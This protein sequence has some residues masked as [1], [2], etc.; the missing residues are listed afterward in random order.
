MLEPTTRVMVRDVNGNTLGDFEVDGD[1]VG[2]NLRE[3]DTG[4]VLVTVELRE[5]EDPD[6]DDED[7]AEA[8]FREH[9]QVI[10]VRMP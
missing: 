2:V 7:E 4:T 8:F 10:P 1:W 5:D 9:V 3:S 6:E